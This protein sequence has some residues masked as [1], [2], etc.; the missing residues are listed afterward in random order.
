MKHFIIK[1][2]FTNGTKEDWHREIARF[3]AGLDA[4]PALKGV[5]YRV[6]KNAKDS[7]YYHLA[8]VVD[9]ASVAALNSRDWFKHY[10]E[11]T[12]AVAGGEVTVLPLEVIAETAPKG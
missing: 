6:M 8:S 5:S 10:T 2:R 11:A 7:D 9:D 3:I 4:D 1:Y 12:K